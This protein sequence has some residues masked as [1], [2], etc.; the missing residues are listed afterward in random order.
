L[1]ISI[2]LISIGAV[3]AAEGDILWEKEYDSTKFDYAHGIAVDSRNNVIVT[4][5]SQAGTG[6]V[7][8]TTIIP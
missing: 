5:K 1:L 8:R 3:Y 7:P 4:G 2:F 6:G